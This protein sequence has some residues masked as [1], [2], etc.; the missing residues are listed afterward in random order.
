MMDQSYIE[1]IRIYKV[2]NGH[3]L[4]FNL[5]GISTEYTFICSKGENL[6]EV[7]DQAINSLLKEKL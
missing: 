6:A 1:N 2:V 7:M 4:Q 5:V 3:V